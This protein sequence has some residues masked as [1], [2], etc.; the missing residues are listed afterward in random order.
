[1]N[2]S[3]LYELYLAHPH[4]TTDSRNCPSNS[5]FF[6]L[7][8]D[9]FNG[10]Q[11]ALQALEKGAAYAIIDEPLQ[12]HDARC[13]VVDNVLL[14]L[15]DLARFHRKKLTIPVLGITGSNGKTTTKELCAAVLRQ[16]YKVHYTKGN[17]NNHIGVPLTILGITPDVEFAIIEMG[18]NH[19]GDI[20][21][22]VEIALPNY[23]I[24]TNVGRA[25]LEGF[26][27][28]EGVIKTKKELYDYILKANGKIFID[29]DNSYLQEMALGTNQISYGTNYENYVSGRIKQV[30]PFVSFEWTKN[31][32]STYFIQTA[33]IG[34][35]NLSNLLAAV[36][37]GVYFGVSA[38]QCKD[39]IEAY[40]PEN[41]RSQYMKT[42]KNELILDAYNAN[43]TSMEAAIRN[44][45]N[46]TTSLPK[47]LILGDMFELGKEAQNEHQKIVDLLALLQFDKVCLVGSLF[48]QTKSNFT[49]LTNGDE[50]V[51]YLQEKDFQG[52]SILIKGSRSMKMERVV[53]FL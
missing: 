36:A 6:A 23:G 32:D 45:K 8:G 5:I 43:P 13:I 28:F 33:L 51:A 10:N 53:E 7:K 44:F 34:E 49:T 21:E 52:L 40:V 16:K 25:H 47:M 41:N 26:G 42:S 48:S 46:I 35:Y 14:T 38:L 18:A 30:S 17:L 37:V 15:Q 20:Q 19:P 39:G 12:I 22:L 2:I 1:M 3:D 4:I 31:D 9:N 24:I 11:Y 27:S 50:L 29:S